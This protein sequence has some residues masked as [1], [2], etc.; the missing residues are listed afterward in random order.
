M[1]SGSLKPCQPERRYVKITRVTINVA[2]EIGPETFP[3][4][5]PTFSYLRSIFPITSNKST[6][7]SAPTQE[8]RR[9]QV[10]EGRQCQDAS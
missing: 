9:G 4:L 10:D 5:L 6:K 3:S 2:T 1:T 7:V 8:N